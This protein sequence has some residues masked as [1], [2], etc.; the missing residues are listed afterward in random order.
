MRLTQKR[1]PQLQKS[2]QEDA[3]LAKENGDTHDIMEK[4]TECVLFADLKRETIYLPDGTFAQSAERTWKRRE[5]N[6]H[7]VM[8]I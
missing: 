3:L 6:N 4:D 1:F 5:E 7:D 8:E 2:Y